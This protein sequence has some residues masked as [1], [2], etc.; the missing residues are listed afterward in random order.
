MTPRRTIDIEVL[1]EGLDVLHTDVVNGPAIS[2]DLDNG[3]TIGVIPGLHYLVMTEAQYEA[4]EV[5]DPDK[6]YFL[7]EEE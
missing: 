3:I 4:L 6:F 5:V 1:T 7:Y 2:V